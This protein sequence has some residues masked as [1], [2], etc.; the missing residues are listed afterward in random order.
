MLN[1]IHDYLAWPSDELD[2][3]RLAAQAQ[4]IRVVALMGPKAALDAH[5][6]R[7]GRAGLAK[8]AAALEPHQL[9]GTAPEA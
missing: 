7:A 1:Q 6:E 9:E 8:L 2:P 4:V 3:H 5:R